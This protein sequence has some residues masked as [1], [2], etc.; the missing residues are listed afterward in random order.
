MCSYTFAENITSRISEFPVLI[1]RPGAPYP[2]GPSWL[3][4]SGPGLGPG[5]GA[6]R[7]GPAGAGKSCGR[8]GQDRRAMRGSRAG[9]RMRPPPT[10]ETVGRVGRVWCVGRV[11][12]T[13]RTGQ[14][15]GM[16]DGERGVP[17]SDLDKSDIARGMT[18]FVCRHSDSG[19]D[20]SIIT[21][22]PQG[23]EL[24]LP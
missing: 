24:V 3:I 17:E 4:V 7:G 13:G 23:S 6:G 16:A 10:Y 1:P 18:L 19:I 11:G 21:T 5:P 20:R 2:A 22:A 12:C 9:K 15:R 8:C 14:A